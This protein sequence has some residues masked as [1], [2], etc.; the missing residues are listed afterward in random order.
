MTFFLLF[1]RMCMQ[2]EWVI[3][4]IF[5]K[6]G[7]EKKTSAFQNLDYLFDPSPSSSPLLA[8][9][10]LGEMQSLD[11]PM[12]FLYKGS[13]SHIFH[14][15]DDL[16]RRLPPMDPTQSFLPPTIPSLPKS[17][18]H[19]HLPKEINP[20]PEQCSSILSTPAEQALFNLVDAD[21]QNPLVLST[22]PPL[23]GLHDAPAWLSAAGGP[24][25]SGALAPWD[26]A[27]AHVWQL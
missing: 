11:S 26:C 12:D 17:D 18:S 10:S 23:F 9:P 27:H 24:P 19:Q 22:F 21:P 25:E 2:E 4:R 6:T 8:Y 1:L 3:C 15:D 16:H 5:K 20:V 14:P 13:T 7:G